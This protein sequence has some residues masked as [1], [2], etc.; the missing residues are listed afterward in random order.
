MGKVEEIDGLNREIFTHAGGERF[1]YVPALN[2]R[3]DH[4]RLLADLVARNL[5]GWF[6][7]ESSLDALRLEAEA[8]AARARAIAACPFAADAGY[9]A[10]RPS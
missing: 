3:P 4:L 7:P 1:R 5:S 8:T 9:G 10:S 6:E 2:D